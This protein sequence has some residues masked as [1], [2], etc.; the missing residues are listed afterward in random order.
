MSIS[1]SKKI[2][3]KLKPQSSQSSQKIIIKKKSPTQ[4]YKITLPHG[5]SW[6]MIY[7]EIPKEIQIDET[8]FETLWKLHPEEFEEGYMHG[9]LTKFPRWSQAYG[10]DYYYS[11]KLHK[12]LPIELQFMKDL[13]LWVQTHS[14]QPYTSILINWYGNGQ[15]YI[16]PH[17]DNESQLVPDSSIY[18]FSFGQ[19]RD[20]VIKSKD[21][22]FRKVI[23]MPSNSLMIMG[24]QMQKY[25]KHE[26]PKRALSTCP[27]RRINFTFRLFKNNLNNN[28]S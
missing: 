19:K 28:R 21:K 11:G 9:Q 10:Q 13:L 6:I 14:G 12:A 5:D 23:P 4:P 7:P 27:Q 3:I 2:A 15:H 17:S 20:F 25:Y 18:S 1:I 16:G 26:V 8:V 22:T 24:K